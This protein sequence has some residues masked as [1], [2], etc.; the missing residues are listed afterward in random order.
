MHDGLVEDA[1]S[2]RAQDV[3]DALCLATLFWSREYQ[4]TARSQVINFSFELLKRAFSEDD[5]GRKTGVGEIRDSH[6]F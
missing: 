1:G 2:A 5:A 4:R 6:G 3:S